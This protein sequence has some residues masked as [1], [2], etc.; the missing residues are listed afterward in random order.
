MFLFRKGMVDDARLF[1]ASMTLALLSTPEQIKQ[2]KKGMNSVL[3]QLLQLVMGAAKGHRFRRNGFH[4]SEPLA[5]LVKLFVVEER[6]LDY[7]LCHAE[8]KPT[9]DMVSTIGLFVSLLDTF[10]KA[11]KGDDR[12]EQFTLIALVNILWSISFQ[13]TYSAELIRH[14]QMISTIR[15]LLEHEDQQELLEQYK[16]RSMESLEQAARG[17][18]HNLNLDNKPDVSSQGNESAEQIQPSR[19]SEKPWLMISYCHGDDA[20]CTRVL[21]LFGTSKEPWQ[22]W[23]DRTH[24]QSAHDLWESIAEGM[25]RASIIVCLLSEQYFESKSCRQEFIYAVDSL[26]KPIV[27][28]LLENFAPKGWLGQWNFIVLQVVVSLLSARDSHVRLEIHPLSR[29]S[30]TK[31]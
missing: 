18:L 25:E 31:S 4:V 16:P 15:S 24:C 29:S 11:R 17:I 28:V 9:S 19:K 3:N 13:P 20:F 2:D 27:P 6:T 26:K 12:L 22:I 1:I 23:I 21:D 8:T 10:A 7:V 14:E 5:V 30:G